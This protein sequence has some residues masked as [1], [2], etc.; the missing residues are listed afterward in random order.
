MEIDLASQEVRSIKACNWCGSREFLL[1]L[2]THQAA[3]MYRIDPAT[4]GK[5]SRQ[6]P[7]L[8]D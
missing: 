6:D 3:F 8:V 2:T 4:L 1:N 7:E 5:R